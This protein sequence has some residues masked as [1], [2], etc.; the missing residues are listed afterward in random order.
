MEKENKRESIS[1]PVRYMLWG[2]AAG[3][4]E[5]C[6]KPLY[7][8]EVT[9]DELNLG[10]AA[11]IVGQGEQGPRSWMVY[12]LEEGKINDLSNL[13]LLC[14]QDHTLIDNNPES[15][16]IEKL[17]KMKQIHEDKVRLATDHLDSKQS[18][19]IIYRGKIGSIQPAI[20][21]EDAKVAMF[22]DYY[23]ADYY[24]HELGMSGNP[25]SDKDEEFWVLERKKLEDDFSEKIQ[26]LLGNECYR[27]HYSIFAYAP[28]P[29]LILL[30]SLLPKKYPAQVYQLK[31]EPASWKWEAESPESFEFITFEPDEDHSIVALNLSLS[32]DIDNDRIY[33]A[34]QTQ[35]VAIWGVSIPETQF[36][37][38]DHLRSKEQLI[39]FSRMFSK[40]MNRIKKRH[41]Q[42]IKLHIFPSMGVAYAVEIGRLWS[43]KSDMPL[44][45]FDQSNGTGGFIHAL[46][47]G[48]RIKNDLSGI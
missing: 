30:G 8:H 28:I 38:D 43:E 39:L 31:K 6:N 18:N 9:Q 20:E 41:G 4:C 34:L 19:V 36:P 11:H 45:I 15:Y 42:N 25:Y 21:Y 27:N 16:P 14:F 10:E 5:F 2:K 12:P 46:D 23:P 22:P 47:I 35:E 13:M 29:L 1:Q 32:A 3:R 48:E 26:R 7:Q 37:K 40:L 17:K 24:A 33:E 44:S